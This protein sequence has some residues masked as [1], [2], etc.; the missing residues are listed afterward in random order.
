[1]ELPAGANFSP[2][3]AWL[4]LRRV[5]LAL[6]LLIAWYALATLPYL[7]DYPLMDW[8][9][10]MIAAPAYKLAAQ[11]V[12]GS[13]MFTGFYHAE[14]RN[15]DHM[16]LY[17]VLLAL[18]F[19]VL[20]FGIVPARLASVV[21]GLAV[22]LLTFELGRRLYDSSVGLAA[23]VALCCVRLGLPNF[24]DVLRLGYQLNMSGM[25]LLDFARVIRFDV[26]VPAWALAACLSFHRACERDSRLGY[27]GA[28]VFT[29]LAALTHLYGA[30]VLPVLIALWLWQRGRRARRSLP[31]ALMLAGFALAV[32]PYA[33]YVLQ[34]A[35]DYLGQM[36][37][38]EARFDLL[39]PAFYWDSW[40]RE[41]WRYVSWLGGSFREPILWP[42]AG[43]WL[44][45][46]GVGAANVLLWKRVR[47]SP[48]L[49][50]RLLLLS[51]PGL[52]ILLALLINLK[53]YAYLALILPFL[54]LQ[55]GFAVVTIWRRA[56]RWVH[57]ALGLALAA[58]LVE[59]GAGLLTSYRI[60]Q[61]TTPYR[62]LT[63]SIRRVIPPDARVLASHVVWFGLADY[64]FRS[65]NLVFVL[66]D[67]QYGYDPA[68]SVEQT[69]RQLD[70]DYVIVEERLLKTYLR[71]P[72][73]A[74]DATVAE[75]WRSLDAYIQRYCPRVATRVP[76][77]DYGDV[78]VYHC[79]ET[80]AGARP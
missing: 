2:I 42:R 41:P 70:P 78:V 49:P 51:L 65:I 67:P 80:G 11:G 43:L 17:P 56:G 24:D 62:R 26:L 75:T 55:L 15:Y 76:A 38:H 66:S 73:S 71:P 20:G 63:E 59:A 29:G 28:G 52:V 36:L 46:F 39:N 58:A 64:D 19:K 22:V 50:D 60:A 5:S 61:S 32:L 1:V 30:F 79:E 23:A 54:A 45:L 34:N 72:V 8:A 69:V 6:I 33:V 16:P 37:R 40:I 25:P 18:S 7:E 31:L 3:V 74:P 12:Y 10:P 48:R 77:A 44:M 9:Q 27:F 14:L 47:R 57:L 35:A 4:R 68:P 13:D 53:R 21:S